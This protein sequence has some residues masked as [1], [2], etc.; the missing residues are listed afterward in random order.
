MKRNLHDK[1]KIPG[2]DLNSV[3]GFFRRLAAIAY[4]SILLLAVLFAATALILPFNSGEAL[5]NWQIIFYRFYLLF[6]SFLFYGWFWTHGGQTLGLRVWKMKVLTL[7][8]QSMTW[9]QAMIRFCFALLSWAAFGLGF[10]WIMINKNSLAW[11]DSLSQSRIF[12]A[13][14]DTQT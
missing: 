13:Q 4:D 8:H 6:V 9:K 14:K 2:A 3:P 12:F 11:H 5:N 1:Q 7:N 10:I